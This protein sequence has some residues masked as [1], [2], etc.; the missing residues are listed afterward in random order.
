MR[1]VF[2]P[3]EERVGEVICLPGL[4]HRPDDRLV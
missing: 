3:G 4:R 1:G 2:L